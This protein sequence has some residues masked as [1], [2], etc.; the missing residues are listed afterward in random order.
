MRLLLS[1]QLDQEAPLGD[2]AS[3]PRMHRLAAIRVPT[4]SANSFSGMGFRP[5]WQR[6]L[7]VV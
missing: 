4:A 2:A 5:T 3:L 7:A 1:R 6:L